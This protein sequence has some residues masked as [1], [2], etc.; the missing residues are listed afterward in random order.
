MN[1]ECTMA[2]GKAIG[3]QPT[4]AEIQNIEA[5][6]A[7]AM[8]KAAAA[9]PKKWL[10]MSAGEQVRVGAAMAAKEIENEAILK[11][12]R[13]V[14]KVVA[15][16][17]IQQTLAAFPGT[18]LEALDHLVAFKADTKG[19]IMSA[20]TRSRAIAVDAT[21]QM[22][23]TLEATSPKFFGLIEDVAGVRDL[24]RELH[25]EKTGNPDAAAGA[26]AFAEITD[27][28]RLRFNRAGGDIG[29]LEDWGMPHHHSQMRVA[30]AG[31]EAWIAEI[32]PRLARERYVGPTGRRLNDAEMQTFLGEAWASIATN[33]ANK[34]ESG[35]R[36]S[37]M[38]ANRNNE[39]RQIHFKSAD[40]YLDYQIKFGEKTP[41][42]TL[43]GHI[44]GISKDIGLVET[45]GPN[46]DATF[47]MFLNRALDTQITGDPV[48]EG[49]YVKH[50]LRVEAMYDGV[51]GRSLPI[52]SPR[53]AEIF[54]NIRNI[55]VAS[56]LGSAVITAITDEGTMR[57]A[58]AVNNLPQM[59]LFTNELATYNPA[60]P[61]EKR[62]AQRAGLGLST[63][64]QSINRFGN[65]GLT[66]GYSRKVASATLRASGMN[67]MTE[68]RRRSFGV[69]M[70]GAY[71]AAVREARTLANLDPDDFAIMRSKGITDTDY[72]VWRRATL[73]DFGGGNDT[74]LTPD[75]IYRIPDEQL[76][77]LG[78]PKI[79]KENAA[80][81]LLGA[82]L[83]ETDLAIIEPGARERAL[84]LNNLQR[85]SVKGEIARSFFLFKSFPIAMIT[86]HWTR[87]MSQ[88]NTGGKVAYG[89][90]LV[91]TTTVLGM[92]ALQAQ[93]VVQGK[94]P[95]DMAEFKTWVQA[96]LKGG[97]FSLY[98]DFLLN[99]TTQYG[100][101]ALASFLGPVASTA[102][103]ALALTIGNAHELARGEDTHAGAEAVKFVKGNL[104][105]AN[106]WYT[107]AATDHLIFHQLQEYLSPGYLERMRARAENDFGQSFWW[108]P[109][110]M[111]PS[112]AP[113]I[114]AAVELNNDP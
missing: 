14:L 60:N 3:R 98:G 90:A 10:S 31:K 69:T 52:A 32:L 15:V 68:A 91:A 62:L 108:E 46:P 5:S 74:M 112:R 93:Q 100:G 84:M 8:R 57:V 110:E 51:A 94:D 37:G 104:P 22:V 103:E 7:S 49:K 41:Y 85:G 95:R 56:K 50:A 107:R 87:A 42:E 26:K 21:R 111:A 45:F 11:Q 9:D 65:E 109:G 44:H 39:S 40:D 81:R 34:A 73:E 25:G 101:S 6:I 113:D 17:N 67:A 18:N 24:V 89:A 23:E 55:M 48:N 29:K 4:D 47:D 92:L 30:A 53:T 33:G 59:K 16:A 1:P 36:G 20:E 82:V 70:M 96:L 72:E 83:E 75:S 13:K 54:D 12:R 99:D 71:G 102:E 79:L 77:D 35:V 88:P 76:A 97:A 106:L 61:M 2:V 105:G 86:R 19:S 78:D 80:T 66:S 27:A 63:L 114:T 28:L 43:I 64:A 38:R 58:A